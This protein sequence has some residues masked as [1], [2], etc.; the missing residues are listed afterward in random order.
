[1]WKADPE[2]LVTDLGDELV[3]LHPTKSQ[4]FGLNAAGRLMW[5]HLPATTDDLTALLVRTYQIDAQRASADVGAVL[6]AL[7]ERQLVHPVHTI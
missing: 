1:M 6:G 3:L 2:V 5:H 7:A 4:M